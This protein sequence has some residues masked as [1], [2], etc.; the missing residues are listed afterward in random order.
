MPCD[1]TQELGTGRG[2]SRGMGFEWNCKPVASQGVCA[3]PTAFF[4]PRGAMAEP[5]SASVPQSLIHEAVLPLPCHPFD[6]PPRSLAPTPP[7]TPGFALETLPAP[8]RFG[9][10][11]DLGNRVSELHFRL[12]DLGNRV[13]KHH[14]R[15]RDLG[16]RVS[17]H[18]F[19]LRDLGNRVSKRQWGRPGAHHGSRHTDSK[20]RDPLYRESEPVFDSCEPQTRVYLTSK[21]PNMLNMKHWWLVLVLLIVGGWADAARD[22]RHLRRMGR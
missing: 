19:R 16:N 6:S 20:D 7:G 21:V 9:R 11:R 8:L 14:F 22:P 12:R 4:P 10:L 18:H 15:L 1:W 13:S 2:Q 17:K 5:A 3:P